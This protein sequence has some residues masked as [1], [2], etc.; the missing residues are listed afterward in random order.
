[1][2]PRKSGMRG[3]WGA[4]IAELGLRLLSQLDIILARN[5]ERDLALFTTVDDQRL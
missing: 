4:V 1:M 5:S 3:T 2:A